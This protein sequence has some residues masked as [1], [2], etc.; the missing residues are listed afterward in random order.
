M[1]RYFP[2][3]FRESCTYFLW[4][5]IFLG[6]ISSAI[7]SCKMKED[8]VCPAYYSPVCGENGKTY[9]SPCLAECDNVQYI[10]GECPVYGVGLVRYLGD[11]AQNGC[12][13]L[14]EI[15]NEKY[16]PLSLDIQFQEP[17]LLVT[18]RYRRLNS[19]FECL[20]PGNHFRE[21]EILEIHSY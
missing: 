17:D 20:D 5:F 2:E 12:G 15:M 4:N 3:K 21:I 18:L 14:I 1:L 6:L 11:T 16:K 9:G 8:C 13:Y 7:I 10:E 19:Y